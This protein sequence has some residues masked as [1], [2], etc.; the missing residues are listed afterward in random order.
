MSAGRKIRR[1][2][3]GRSLCTRAI[4]KHGLRRNIYT[5]NA[6]RTRKKFQ[7][8]S[9]LTPKGANVLTYTYECIALSRLIQTIE[10]GTGGR[11]RRITRATTDVRKACNFHGPKRETGFLHQRTFEQDTF[12]WSSITKQKRRSERG[13][14]SLFVRK[15]VLCTKHLFSNSHVRSRTNDDNHDLDSASQFNNRILI[16]QHISTIEI[17]RRAPR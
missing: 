7:N 10:G 15:N 5:R 11:E 17:G 8:N 13:R 1:S 3:H 14:P 12:E 9:P 2:S 4:E 6:E 16:L